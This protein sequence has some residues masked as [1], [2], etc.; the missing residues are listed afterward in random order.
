MTINEAKEINGRLVTAGLWNL[1][2]PNRGEYP[3][4]QSYSL[5]QMI[6]ATRLVQAANDEE[7][8]KP[9]IHTVSTVCADRLIAALYVHTWFPVCQ[10]DDDGIESIVSDGKKALVLIRVLS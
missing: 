1:G 8:G 4:L 9:G 7:V 6:E 5:P 10:Q 3:D 2:L